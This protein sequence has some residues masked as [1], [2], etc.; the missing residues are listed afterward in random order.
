VA[1]HYVLV[2]IT[3]NPIF[4]AVHDALVDWLTSQRTLALRRRT[5]EPVALAGHRRILD[6]V[7]AGDA[8]AAG[9]AMARHL[10]DI[11]ELIRG[12]SE[13]MQ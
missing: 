6:A 13:V 2:C 8:E 12:A 10:R 9:E 3:G 7:A 1:F 5:A 11:A 4:S